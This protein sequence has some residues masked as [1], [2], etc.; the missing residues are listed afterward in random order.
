MRRRSVIHVNLGSEDRIYRGLTFSVYDKGTGIPRDGKPKA[1]VEVLAVDRQIST[2]R[3]LS[4]ERKNPIGVG[5][6]VANLIW[7]AGRQNQFVVAGEFDLDR[8]GTVDYDGVRKIEGLVQ[9][10][11]GIVAE[12][13]SASTDYVILGAKPLVPA[14][15]TLV[16][17][18]NDPTAMERYNVARQANDHYE[19]IRQRAESLWVP[20]FNYDRFLYFTG[21]AD[22]VGK[23]GAF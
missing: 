17:Q 18:T 4:S 11:G 3:I 12:D 14:E 1:Q 7:D 8:D 16:E 19:T 20:I 13:V 22:Q 2:A 10:W 15:P 23:P 5:D 21:F 6:S 9:R